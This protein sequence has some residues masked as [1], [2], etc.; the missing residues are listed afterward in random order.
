VNVQTYVRI[1]A[2]RLQGFL[3]RIQQ[4][5]FPRGG[6]IGNKGFPASL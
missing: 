5:P 6:M 1:L 3:A 4:H 2:K